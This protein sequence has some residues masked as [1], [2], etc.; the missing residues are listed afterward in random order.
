MKT[1]KGFT[2][3]ET[4]L[5]MSITSIVILGIYVGIINLI[6]SANKDNSINKSSY[7]HLIKYFHDK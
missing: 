4:I 2:L 5:Y 6:Q 7:D 1:I 3:I